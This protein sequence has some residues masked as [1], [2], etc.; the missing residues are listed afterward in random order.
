MFC[1]I[2]MN[3]NIWHEVYFGTKNRFCIPNSDG[4]FRNHILELRLEI[5]N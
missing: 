1:M 2:H 5:H 4:P 3:V